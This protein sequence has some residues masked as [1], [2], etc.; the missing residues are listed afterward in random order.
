MPVSFSGLQLAFEFVSSGGMGENEA[1]LGRQS[2][3]I[4]WHSARL[5]PGASGIR[6][7]DPPRSNVT[8]DTVISAGNQIVAAISSADAHALSQP[9]RA[10]PAHS[11][12]YPDLSRGTE[13]LQ[14]RRWR[15]PDSNHRYRMTLTKL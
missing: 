8:L 5:G 1:Y 11:R 15:K 13:G 7:L 12:E 10:R 14:T 2:G 9:R 6:T 4:Y 3:R